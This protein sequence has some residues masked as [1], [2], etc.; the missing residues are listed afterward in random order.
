M[1]NDA[2]RSRFRAE[3]V[4]QSHPRGRALC[5]HMHEK[6]EV[7]TLAPIATRRAQQDEGHVLPDGRRRQYTV[8]DTGPKNPALI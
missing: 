4:Q 7:T 3:A 2:A 6:R 8:H 5:Q 1:I